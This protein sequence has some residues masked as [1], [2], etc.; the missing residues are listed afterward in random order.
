VDL[1]ALALQAFRP[2]KQAD[3]VSPGET[4]RAGNLSMR[5]DSTAMLARDREAIQ[6]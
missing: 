1:P 5:Q 2:A 4:A 3:I 6:Q